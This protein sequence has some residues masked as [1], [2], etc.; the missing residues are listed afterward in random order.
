MRIFFTHATPGR[1]PA[2]RPGVRPVLLVLAGLLI[3]ALALAKAGDLDPGFGTA[4][5]VVT[6]FGGDERGN[7]VAVA[8]DGMIYVGGGSRVPGGNVDFM[9]ARYTVGGHLDTTWGTGGR[10]VTDL[11]GHDNIS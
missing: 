10:V 2:I 1:R 11:G 8:K 9:V 7:A 6:D 4:G 3:P 5:T